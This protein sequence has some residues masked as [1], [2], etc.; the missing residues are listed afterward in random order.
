VLRALALFGLLKDN[1]SVSQGN[2]TL[3]IIFGFSACDTPQVSV[4]IKTSIVVIF[5]MNR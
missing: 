4:P 3:K 5:G 2:S 1:Q